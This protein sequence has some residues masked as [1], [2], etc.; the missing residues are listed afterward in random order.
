M[1]DLIA[2]GLCPDALNSG[3]L[4]PPCLAPLFPFQHSFKNLLPPLLRISLP[5]NVEQSGKQEHAAYSIGR[6]PAADKGSDEFQGRKNG[7]EN[8]GAAQEGQ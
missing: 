4:S 8:E 3:V 5:H 2:P 6:E 1:I 7:H